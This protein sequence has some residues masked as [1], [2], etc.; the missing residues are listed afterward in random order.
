MAVFWVRMCNSDKPMGNQYSFF[1]D[2]ESESALH[3]PLAR[4]VNLKSLVSSGEN[5]DYELASGDKLEKAVYLK[6][7]VQ[8]ECIKVALLS[9]YRDVD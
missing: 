5:P 1:R 2:M 7:A 4:V 6:L 3:H 8:N 9:A